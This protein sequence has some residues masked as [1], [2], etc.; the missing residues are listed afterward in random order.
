VFGQHGIHLPRRAADQYESGTPIEQEA[1]APGDLVFFTTVAPGASHVGVSTGDGRFVHAPNQRG[2]VRVEQLG[3]E[4]WK[5]R[6]VGAR[7]VV[8]E[9]PSRR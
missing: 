9:N 7:R 4:Y 8:G 6:Y 2:R 5:R 3:T 1:L